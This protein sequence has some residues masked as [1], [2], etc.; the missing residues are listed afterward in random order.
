M[1]KSIRLL[2]ALGMKNFLNLN[3]VFHSTDPKRKRRAVLLTV[4]GV[5]LAL[6]FFAYI[7][8]YT[9]GLCSF[10]MEALVLPWL[11]LLPS[12]LVFAVGLFRTGGT[13]F[14]R[15][16]YDILGSLPLTDGMIVGSRFLCCY[17]ESLLYSLAVLVPGLLT[18]AV[19]LHPGA[20]VVLRF[21]LCIPFVPLLPL[22]LT[23]FFSTLIKRIAGKMRN[24]SLVE[25]G[26]TLLLV[27]G[28]LTFETLLGSKS[29]D[30]S[31]KELI[32]LTAAL[33]QAVV[34]VYPLCG[35]FAR[36]CTAG[37][38]TELCKPVLL[39]VGVTAATLLLTVQF[40]RP[41]S[42]RMG[43][44]MRSRKTEAV[45]ESR[46][47]LRSLWRRE[48]KRY[49][50]SSIYVTNTAIGP[51]LA[52]AGSVAMLFVNMEGMVPANVS[53]AAVAPFLLCSVLCMMPP[54]AVSISMEGKQRWI[55]QSLP[56]PASALLDAK[57]L[58]SL[59]IQWPCALLS[60]A[61]LCFALHPG[62]ADGV[63]LFLIPLLIG[64]FTVE[65]ALCVDAHLGSCEWE[66][67]VTVVKQSASALLGG[68]PPLL[69]GAA[70]AFAALSLPGQFFGVIRMAL[71]VFLIVG[72]LLLR[73]HNCKKMQ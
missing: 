19:C 29:E 25:T 33:E 51:L 12:V 6:M 9:Y 64:L 45:G 60:S 70:G 35:W 31:A 5:L 57:A 68:M 37:T 22:S 50:A 56:I 69:L 11:F 42:E 53:L 62:F 7:A 26:L 67:E 27:G 66:K 73:K 52:L 55:S 24:R 59:S 40:F 63:F 14:A 54:A 17:L 3:A 18:Y 20:A 1:A 16:G 41:I 46:S 39:S 34:G 38:I 21:V 44:T 43:S 28:I 4:V 58:L 49:L 10:G 13:L 2:T 30:M 36:F 32:E 61:V 23:V 48:W 65:L 15:H 72:A 47:L 71:C 8:L